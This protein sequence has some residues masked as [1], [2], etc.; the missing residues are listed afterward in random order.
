MTRQ[1]LESERLISPH[2]RLR[3]Q[4][5]FFLY[6]SPTMSVPGFG[7]LEEK[8][9]DDI[10]AGLGSPFDTLRDDLEADGDSLAGL[11][12]G[13]HELDPAWDLNLPPEPSNDNEH[14]N[15]RRFGLGRNVGNAFENDAGSREED[16]ERAR[17]RARAAAEAARACARPDRSGLGASTSEESESEVLGSPSRLMDDVL[18]EVRRRQEA[19]REASGPGSRRGNKQSV[20]T[21]FASSAPE[22]FMNLLRP[23]IDCRYREAEITIENLKD[24]TWRGADGKT[25]LKPFEKRSHKAADRVTAFPPLHGG[26]SQDGIGVS[27]VEEIW[28]ELVRDLRKALIESLAELCETSSP[29]MKEELRIRSATRGRV[30]PEAKEEEE[31]SKGEDLRLVINRNG[32]RV[33]EAPRREKG[34]SNANLDPQLDV[35]RFIAQYANAS[36]NFPNAYGTAIMIAGDMASNSKVSKWFNSATEYTQCIYKSSIYRPVT[37]VMKDGHTLDCPLPLAMFV[38]TERGPGPNFLLGGHHLQQTLLATCKF[39]FH[40]SKMNGVMKNFLSPNNAFFTISEHMANYIRYDTYLGALGVGQISPVG[41]AAIQKQRGMLTE[42]KH[43]L[44]NGSFY[45]AK[46]NRSKVHLTNAESILE[47]YYGLA[48]VEKVDT[49]SNIP[50]EA[51]HRDD[52]IPRVFMDYSTIWKIRKGDQTE[53]GYIWNHNGPKTKKVEDYRNPESSYPL[54][55]MLNQAA[56]IMGLRGELKE[57]RKAVGRKRT[58]VD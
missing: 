19:A 57:I 6:T 35:Y 4:L 32:K 15:G 33:Q 3:V 14:D 55:W 20:Y 29:A 12:Y 56:E 10:T 34:P 45:S 36:P 41:S 1:G 7:S 18:A 13:S 46:I 51:K 53:Q 38:D 52:R 48:D 27:V 25:N 22:T 31:E 50:T 21:R 9:G 42:M 40:R 37:L 54:D 2:T 47:S 5:S 16:A 24:E 44:K 43:T 17:M 8:D 11:G 30:F 58:R 28:T 26:S 23:L 39:R 49:S